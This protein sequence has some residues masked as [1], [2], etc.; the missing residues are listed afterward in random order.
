MPLVP[1]VFRIVLS[2]IFMIAPL[3][4]DHYRATNFITIPDDSPD[5]SPTE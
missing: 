2:F 4:I 5:F 1:P 3:E